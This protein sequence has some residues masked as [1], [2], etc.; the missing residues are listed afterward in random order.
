MIDRIKAWCKHSVTILL[1]R[2]QLLFGIVLSVLTAVDV[3]PIVQALPFGKW[4]GA[5]VAA[6]GIATE[7]ARRRT[8]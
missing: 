6:F 8:L 1:A 3:T 7:L 4:T 5:I 2:V